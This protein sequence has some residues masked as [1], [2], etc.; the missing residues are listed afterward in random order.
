MKKILVVD[1]DE[2]IRDSLVCILRRADFQADGASG[3]MSA[4]DKYKREKSDCVL[5]D[6]D[7]P[8][9]SGIKVFELIREFDPDACVY[10]LS[11]SGEFRDQ[12]LAMGARGFF[13]KPV[14]FDKFLAVLKAI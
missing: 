3:G 8:D 12:V 1:D 13:P 11:G 9:I 10:F 2:F 14:E 6:V 5:L 7:L 4:V